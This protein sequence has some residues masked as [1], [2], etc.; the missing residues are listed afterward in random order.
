MRYPPQSIVRASF[1]RLGR[2]SLATALSKPLEP[3]KGL[4]QA[5]ETKVSVRVQREE[6]PLE[7]FLS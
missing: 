1:I 4:W 5:T 2:D 3:K 6:G 7:C